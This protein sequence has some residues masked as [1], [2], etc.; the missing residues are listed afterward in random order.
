MEEVKF[1]QAIKVGDNITDI[2]KVSCVCSCI[3]YVFS[4]NKVKYAFTVFPLMM[5]LGS[6]YKIAQTG[7]WLCQD[8]DNLWHILTEEEYE[9]NQ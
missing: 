1:K 7:D 3:K 8:E 2:M 9:R 6:K 4:D 5:V